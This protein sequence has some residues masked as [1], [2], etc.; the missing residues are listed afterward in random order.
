MQYLVSLVVSNSTAICD[1]P[2]RV[3][4]IKSIYGRKIETLLVN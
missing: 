3:D 2:N 4:K 1:S